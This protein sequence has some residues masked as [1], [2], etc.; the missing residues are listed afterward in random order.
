M[1]QHRE[2]TAKTGWLKF[3]K[4]GLSA[5]NSTQMVREGMSGRTQAVTE[6]RELEEKVQAQEQQQSHPGFALETAALG[7]ICLWGFNGAERSW[8][9]GDRAGTRIPPSVQA[10]NLLG[11]C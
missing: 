11:L 9:G 6:R 8:A 7:F 3:P 2:L 1:E 4:M 5:L 10:P